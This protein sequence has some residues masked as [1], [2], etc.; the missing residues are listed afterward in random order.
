VASGE[1]AGAFKVG[2]FITDKAII[3]SMKDGVATIGSATVN[4]TGVM[5]QNSLLYALLSP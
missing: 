2:D 4:V 1:L 5:A 3:E